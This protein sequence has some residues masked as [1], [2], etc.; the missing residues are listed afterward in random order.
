[1]ASVR[2]ERAGDKGVSAGEHADLS[3]HDVEIV[4]SKIGMASKD[5][6]RVVAEAVRVRDVKI[7]FALYA[8]K[9]EF[10]PAAMELRDA[11]LE[12]AATPYL[13]EQGSKLVMEGRD[14]EPNATGVYDELYGTPHG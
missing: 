12:G 10:G 11:R 5:K 1:V 9:S 6:S 7:G 13:L 4:D 8:K 14:V 3:V 2:I